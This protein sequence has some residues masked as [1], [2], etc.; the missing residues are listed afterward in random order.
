MPQTSAKN[1][2][3]IELPLF[4]GHG[5][6]D[7]LV[8]HLASERLHGRVGSNDKTLKLYEGFY[9]EILNEPEREQ[10]MTDM[11]QWLDARV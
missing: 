2:S 7:A 3:S 5:T 6:D 11:L 9:H 10:V 4:I 1:A 8:K